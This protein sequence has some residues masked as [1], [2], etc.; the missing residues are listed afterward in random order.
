MRNA[1]FTVKNRSAQRFD[2][3]DAVEF[4]PVDE[5]DDEL[6]EELEEELQEQE[7][8]EEEADELDEYEEEVVEEEEE[9]EEPEYE[10]VV[11]EVPVRR[12]GRPKKASAPPAR[13]VARSAKPSAGARLDE[14]LAALLLGSTTQKTGTGKFSVAANEPRNPAPAA[15][16]SVY[17]LAADRTI[18]AFDSAP[19]AL[20]PLPAAVKK[21]CAPRRGGWFRFCLKTLTLAGFTALA[22][23]SAYGV[24]LES[25]LPFWRET[26]QNEW[27]RFAG[28]VSEQVHEL[29]GLIL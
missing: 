24:S 9:I 3:F 25:N 27:G 19:T 15:V 17:S 12:R 10:E 20:K 13:R 4:T 21:R 26:L 8:D 1:K 11:E 23:W 28:I 5:S 16:S 18:P 14:D 2:A 22:C 7:Y 29:F 6:D